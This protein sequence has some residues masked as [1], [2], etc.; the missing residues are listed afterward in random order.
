MTAIITPDN[1]AH[2]IAFRKARYGH[3]TWLVFHRRDGSWETRQYSADAIKAAL[4]AVGTQGRFF[5][6]SA[7]CGTPNLCR[8]WHYGVYL[9][10]CAR[11]AERHGYSA[12]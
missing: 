6:Y 8:S 1:S 7:N 10:R 2:D 4:I 12:A 11:G 9:W 3:K 5:W